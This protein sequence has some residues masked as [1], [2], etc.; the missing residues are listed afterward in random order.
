MPEKSKVDYYDSLIREALEMEIDAIEAP[1]GERAWK[2]IEL[3]LAKSRTSVRRPL[4]TWGRAAVLAAACL[5]F[6][7]GGIGVLRVIDPAIHLAD[8]EV[9]DE[10]ATEVG[11]LEADNEVEQFA[12]PEEEIPRVEADY[13]VSFGD[14]D[15]AP[16]DWPVMLPGDYYP[17]ENILLNRAGPPVYSAAIYYGASADLLLVKKK[18]AHLNLFDF[19]NHLGGHMQIGIEDLEE[20]N[21]FVSFKAGDYKGLAWQ[22]NGRS[23]ALLVLSGFVAKEELEA[24]AAST[25]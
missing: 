18:N 12:A 9:A 11:L 10:A 23:Q 6:V 17:S 13:D 3:S 15:P 20:I 25:Y 8:S 22:L 16:P 24:I 21:G 19:V 1:S 7:L 14:F 4:F 5:V 2:N